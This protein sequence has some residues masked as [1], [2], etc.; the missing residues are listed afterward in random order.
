ME[1]Q[2]SFFWSLLTV[3]F[4]STLPLLVYAVSSVG[5]SLSEFSLRT[6][7]QTSH[8]RLAVLMLLN[9]A[10][11]TAVSVWP[12][13]RATLSLALNAIAGMV[14]AAVPVTGLS[15]PII[16]LLNGGFAVVALRGAK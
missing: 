16:G 10:A 8:K 3:A 11:A 1:P 7:V 6:F 9:L 4:F 2:T 12:E 15:D 5:W 13:S 14:G